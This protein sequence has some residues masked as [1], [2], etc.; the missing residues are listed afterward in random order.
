MRIHAHANVL[1]AALHKTKVVSRALFAIIFA[2]AKLEE[3]LCLPL[4][5]RAPLSVS[6]EP[7]SCSMKWSENC[8][9]VAGVDG[10]RLGLLHHLKV[11]CDSIDRDLFGERAFVV[12]ME[13]EAVVV[14]VVLVLFLR[15]ARSDAWILDNCEIGCFNR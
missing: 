8:M 7:H 10:C 11:R 2:V 14:L 6:T 1:I 4:T 12:D 3:G 13:I 15:L 5:T 9:L